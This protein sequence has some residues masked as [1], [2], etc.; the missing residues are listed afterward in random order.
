MGISDIGGVPVSVLVKQSAPRTKKVFDLF[1]KSDQM[2][3]LA[4][5]YEGGHQPDR[6]V[7][8]RKGAERLKALAIKS[9]EDAVAGLSWV[10]E[11][12]SLVSDGTPEA[13]KWV[14][15]VTNRVKLLESALRNLDSVM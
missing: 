10:H 8:L 6:A 1:E 13:K 7:N 11:L 4:D 5:R 15:L 2:S 14:F 12:P 3:S 9:F